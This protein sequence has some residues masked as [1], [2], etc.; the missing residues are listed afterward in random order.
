MNA[1]LIRHTRVDAP[2]GLCYGW[3]D[4]PLAESWRDDVA[5]VQ[6]NLPWSPCE[7]WTSPAARCRTPAE[8]LGAERIVIEPRLRE[9]SMGDWEG[10]RWEDFRGPE[11][12]AWALDP[13]R[14][15]PPGGESAEAFW[16]RVEDVR[17]QAIVA[18]IE[19]L[20]I[21]THAGVIRAWRGLAK[22]MNFSTALREPVPFGSIHL[23]D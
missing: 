10:R 4:V 7:V 23:A 15:S 14:L 16:A 19:R 2:P 22:G 11:S 18:N 20:A 13:W 3:R 8:L 12:E 1:I 5:A 17:T 6:A 21:V 9:L